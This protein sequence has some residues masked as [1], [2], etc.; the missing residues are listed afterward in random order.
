[1]RTKELYEAAIAELKTFCEENTHFSVEV[2]ENVYPIEVRFSPNA[3]QISFFKDEY[4]NEDGEIGYVSIFGGIE[5]LVKISL[6]LVIENSLLKKLVSKAEAV[7]KLY[8]HYK[9]EEAIRGKHEN[10]KNNL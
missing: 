1:M 10:G 9:C 8:C 5:P 4:V 6:K 2:I 7:T 3:T